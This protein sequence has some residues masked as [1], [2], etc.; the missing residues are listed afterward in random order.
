MNN[1]FEWMLLLPLLDLVW[2]WPVCVCVYIL[3]VT[4]DYFCEC[5][6]PSMLHVY[7]SICLYYAYNVH[8]PLWFALHLASFIRRMNKKTTEKK[9]VDC[10]TNVHHTEI[11]REKKKQQHILKCTETKFEVAKVVVAK[12]CSARKE[13]GKKFRFRGSLVSYRK[14]FSPTYHTT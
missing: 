11:K 2:W 7:Q 13:I 6:F 4:C 8:F 3:C 5:V 10:Q 9:V 1:T 14:V 12:R